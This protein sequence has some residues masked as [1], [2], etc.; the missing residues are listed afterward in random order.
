MCLTG[1]WIA[2]ALNSAGFEIRKFFAKSAACLHKE[3][4]GCA[5]EDI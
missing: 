1:F 5:L 2:N 3:T 4:G